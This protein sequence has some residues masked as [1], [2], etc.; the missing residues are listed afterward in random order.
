MTYTVNNTDNSLQILLPDEQT[1][2][3]YSVTLLGRNVRNF[4][5]LV[6]ENSIKQM[7]SFASETAP[8]NPLV[9]QLWYD[10]RENLLTVWTGGVWRRMGIAYGNAPVDNLVPGSAYFDSQTQLL[11]IYDGSRFLP[12]SYPGE[13]VGNSGAKSGTRLRNIFLRDTSDVPRSVLALTYVADSETTGTQLDD[14]HEKIMAIFSDVAFDVGNFNSSTQGEIVNYYAEINNFFGGS[15]RKGLTLRTEYAQTAVPLAE[16]ATSADSANGILVS[17]E[18]IDSANII[19]TGRGYIPADDGVRNLGSSTKRFSSAHVN[20]FVAHTAITAQTTGVSI[21]E[22]GTPFANLFITDATVGNSITV[23]SVVSTDTVVASNADIT[24][25]NISGLLYPGADGTVGQAIVTD[26]NGNLTFDTI[27]SGLTGVANITAGGGVGF[28]PD[29][30]Y[31]GNTAITISVDS[32]VVRTT[33]GGV[34]EISR[35]TE[36]SAEL[37]TANINTQ[38][39]DIDMG[40][41]VLTFGGLT[42]GGSLV[43]DEILDEDTL[44]SNSNTAL[45]TQQSIKA[46]VDNTVGGGGFDIAADSGN[47]ETVS[48]TVGD[49]LTVAGGNNISTVVTATDTITVSL[50]DDV[51]VTGNITAATFVGELTGNISGDAATL[52]GNTAAYYRNA[53]NL[54][55]GTLDSDRLPDLTVDDFASAAIQTS[56]DSFGD[57]DTSLMTAAAVDDLIVGKGYSTTTGTVTSVSG[58]TGLSGTV[59]SSGNL[60]FDGNSLP[61]STTNGHGDSFV[62]VDSAD[63]VSRRLSKGN[64]NISGFNNDAGFTTNVGDITGVTAGNG[65]IGGGNSG[66]VTLNVASDQRG[67]IYR[68]GRD[69]QDYISVGTTTIDFYLDGALDMRLENDGDL[70][71]DGDVIAFSTTT[72]SDERLKENISTIDDALTKVK[73]LDGVEFTWKRDGELSAGVI[74]QQVEQVLPQ[75]VKEKVLPL[76][77]DDGESYKTVNYNQL[78]ALMIQAI[79]ELSHRVEQ[80]E[81]GE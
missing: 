48:V 3:E 67:V 72:S 11:R 46:Y 9:G 54:N 21:G 59:T 15:I 74:A 58:G 73:Q 62:V 6:A 51:T 56:S 33:G 17:G 60:A 65:L 79:K 14:A 76:M 81:R 13:V 28:T 19:H 16:R 69:N 49:T 57:N 45:A 24:T 53:T 18:I 4:G 10:K 34:Q 32:T 77:T 42:S 43:I 31:D 70:H 38:N 37:L 25:A 52:N 78:T 66:S 20:Q 64:I 27:I 7:E 35:A 29:Q 44:S 75:S 47:A 61:S 63:G 26:G 50:D 36:F 5:E 41:G 22:S 30:P 55:T 1:N 2:T 23:T 8:T 40:T 12:A 71:V 80:L 39:N 68:I